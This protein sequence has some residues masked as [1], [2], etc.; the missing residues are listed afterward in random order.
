MRI[1]LL[2]AHFSGQPSIIKPH[3]LYNMYTCIV[4]LSYYWYLFTSLSH[5]FS[6]IGTHKW[7]PIVQHTD[8]KSSRLSRM[9]GSHALWLFIKWYLLRYRKNW[10]KICWNPHVLF[11]YAT[12]LI[13][14][15]RAKK[16]KNIFFQVIKIAYTVKLRYLLKIRWDCL[17]ITRYLSIRDI[18][19]KIPFKKVVGT[20]KF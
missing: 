17:K 11:H 6:I 2:I 18:E 16:N 10:L 20:N 3:N 12:L 8:R 13:V 1:L 4:Y 19:D 14:I 9:C 5:I 7:L 15:V